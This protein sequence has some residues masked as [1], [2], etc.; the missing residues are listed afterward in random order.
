MEEKLRT[1]NIVSLYFHL[2]EKSTHFSLN[3]SRIFSAGLM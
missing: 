3:V 2:I 1:A